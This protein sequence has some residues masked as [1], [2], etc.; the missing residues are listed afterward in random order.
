MGFKFIVP[1]VGGGV[2]TPV[3]S[4]LR[5]H[6]HEDQELRIILSY[7]VW[8]SPPTRDS[9]EKSECLPLAGAL[10]TQSWAKLE[11]PQDSLNFRD[12]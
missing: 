5:E 12:F 1:A 6:R 4:V 11:N 2:C 10:F 3:I 8:A 7:G 9:T